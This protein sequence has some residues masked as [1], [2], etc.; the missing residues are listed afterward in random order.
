VEYVWGRDRCGYERTNPLTWYL[1]NGNPYYWRE[2]YGLSAAHPTFGDSRVSFTNC[3]AEPHDSEQ[4][5][6]V[7]RWG[8]YVQDAFTI[9][10]RLT[11]NGGLRMDYYNGSL[12][13]AVTTGTTGL[14]LEIGHSLQSD[15][16]FNPF[17]LFEMDPIEDAMVFTVLS[18]RIGLTYDLFGDG[19][20]A[21][22]LAYSR[23]YEQVPTWRFG[24]ISPAVLA[25]YE[26]NW[27]DLNGNGALDSPG[28]DN[29]TPRNGMGQFTLPDRDYLISRVDPDLKAP[30]YDE[31]V[32]SINHELFKNFAVKA[33]YLYKRGGDLRGWALYDR[34]TGNFWYNLDEAPNWWVP[35][36]TVVP[37]YG[38][39]PAQE[40]TVYFRSQDSPWNNQFYLQT[41]IPE[42]KHRYHGF[43]LS[44][45]KRYADGWALGGS[46]V[47]SKYRV[48]T[49]G[50][51]PNDF[52]NGFGLS[53]DSYYGLDQ[54]LAIKLFGSFDLPFGFVGSFFF[55]HN[56]GAP[57]GRT[58]TVA[59]PADWA[60]A[61]NALDWEE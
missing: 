18:P 40:V 57:F 51:S 43:E 35:F 26:F 6:V 55:I 53:N 31:V 9:Q 30:Y 34:D 44:F 32:A 25:Q 4:D 16:G 11:I 52:V 59:P 50:D 60:A 28:V 24:D 58:V 23:F 46:V 14:A 29:Y 10:N 12:G 2:Y 22:K 19:K 8:A 42:S 1:Y 56:S 21:V 48:Q 54:P 49:A 7:N 39:Y 47:I 5:L 3:G 61:N 27:F 33:Q 17:G 36:T 20:T 13:K 38:E 45:D 15:L 37:A 41:N